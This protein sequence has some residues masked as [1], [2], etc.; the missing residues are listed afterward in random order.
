M[1]PLTK[2]HARH[3]ST[4][5]EAIIATA[6]CS[7]TYEQPPR[8]LPGNKSG[9]DAMADKK[10]LSKDFEGVIW[11][12]KVIDPKTK[13]HRLVKKP[14]AVVVVRF[15]RRLELPMPSIQAKELAKSI[16]STTRRQIKYD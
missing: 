12:F 8:G 16:T 10:L 14:K 15:R 4:T 9:G 2:D 5:I 13:K 1:G 11:E 6:L 7:A 3:I